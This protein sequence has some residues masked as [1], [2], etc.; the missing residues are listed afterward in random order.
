MSP[1]EQDVVRQIPQSI[2]FG[3]VLALAF[4]TAVYAVGLYSHLCEWDNVWMSAARRDRVEKNKQKNALFMSC[5]DIHSAAVNMFKTAQSR[6]GGATLP[7]PR[8]VLLS[9]AAAQ[10][11]PPYFTWCPLWDTT[12]ILT[13]W[14]LSVSFR[15]F[16]VSGHSAA[17]KEAKVLLTI[18]RH[19]ATSIVCGSYLASYLVS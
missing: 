6:G 13:T 5:P 8:T 11:T 16:L 2:L 19:G 15:S 1:T 17:P 10:T 3:L 9:S 4:T 12:T 7:S 14:F 18:K